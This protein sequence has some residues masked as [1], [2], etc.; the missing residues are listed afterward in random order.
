MPLTGTDSSGLPIQYSFSSS[1]P[2]VSLS[3]VSP[4]TPSLQLSVTGTDASGDAYS[5]TII[6]K[7][8]DSLTPQSTARI[9]QLVNQ[10]S[11]TA[12]H[13]RG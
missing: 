6:I 13:F 1:D 3:L 2:N 12:P 7:L 11:T 4:G 5:G 10:G 8:F 9:E